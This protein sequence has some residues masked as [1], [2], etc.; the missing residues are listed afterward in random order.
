MMNTTLRKRQVFLMVAAVVALVAIWTAPDFNETR[1]GDITQAQKKLATAPV[2]FSGAG[3]PDVTFTAELARS[4]EEQHIGLMFRTKMNNDEGMLFTYDEPQVL[5]MW[6]KNTLLP[7]DM[8]FIDKDHKV[9]RI[10]ENAEPQTLNVRSSLE[11][12]IA[13]L[14][15]N[16]GVAA[17][18]KLKAGD[19]V[20][21][22]Q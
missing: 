22:P 15:L 1:A 21:Y 14:E 16:A 13:V 2:V 18:Q 17:A 3:H 7:L 8:V 5:T 10:E 11:P 12:A 6:M 4:E 20:T 19:L 9:I